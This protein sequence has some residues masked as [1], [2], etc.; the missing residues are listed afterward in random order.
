M[1]FYFDPSV[2]RELCTTVNK[3]YL[4]VCKKAI[5]PLSKSSYYVIY[6]LTKRLPIRKHLPAETET[7]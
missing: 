6:P 2:I 4:T 7:K 3:A 1:P 5:E